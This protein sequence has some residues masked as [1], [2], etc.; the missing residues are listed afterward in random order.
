MGLCPFGDSINMHEMR[1]KQQRAE[2]AY[3]IQTGGAVG[4]LR[5]EEPMRTRV[6]RQSFL[7]KMDMN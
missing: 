4:T 1:E 6:A 5:R 3:I 7:E 2:E